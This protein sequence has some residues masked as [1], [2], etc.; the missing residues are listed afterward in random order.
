MFEKKYYK[1]ENEW[2]TSVCVLFGDYFSLTGSMTPAGESLG[3][4]IAEPTTERHLQYYSWEEISKEEAEEIFRRIDPDVTIDEIEMKLTN[5]PWVIVIFSSERDFQAFP[6][7][8]HAAYANA[9]ENGC[10]RHSGYELRR[11]PNFQEAK[12]AYDEY[13]SHL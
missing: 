6:P 7:M 13:Y 10:Y 3:W 8:P 5:K 1:I 4:E 9:Y 12:A 2:G 11:F